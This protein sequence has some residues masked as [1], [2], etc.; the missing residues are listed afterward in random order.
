VFPNSFARAARWIC[1][2]LLATEIHGL[3]KATHDVL[4]NRFQF[5]SDSLDM[6]YHD[7]LSSD[8]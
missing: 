4:V 6:T 1:R 5:L 7:Q 8:G 3:P 2:L